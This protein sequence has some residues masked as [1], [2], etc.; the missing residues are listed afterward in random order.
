MCNTQWITKYLVEF[1]RLAVRVQWGDT[2]LRHQLYNRLLPRIK[3]EISQVGKPDNLT[4][5]RLLAQSI[6]AC[7]WERRSEIAHETPAN[8]SQ[9]KSSDK[10]KTPATLATQN[11][12]PPK[13][14]QSSTPWNTPA[15][16]TSNTPKPASTLALKLRKDG[17]LTQEERQRCMD[18][19]LCLF[20]GKPGHIAKECLKATSAAAKARATTAEKAPDNSSSAK[21]PKK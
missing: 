5:L 17:R 4:D 12:N 14:G 21:E 6:D 18:N 15:P 2:P 13:S 16:T 8:K 9:D 10:G 20:C 3:D 19:N 7:Y 11:T 1:N